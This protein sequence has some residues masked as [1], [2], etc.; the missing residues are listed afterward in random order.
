MTTEEIKEWLTTRAAEALQVEAHQVDTTLPLTSQGLDS[1]TLLDLT[2][3]L[4][5]WLG[6]DLSIPLLWQHPTIDALSLHLQEGEGDFSD[7]SSW[8]AP[9]DLPL[10]LSFAQERIWRIA[11]PRASA[12][13]NI[14]EKTFHLRGPVDVGL[15]D[16]SLQEVILRH[17][18]LRTTFDHEDGK[19]FQVV[20]PAPLETLQYSDV[21]SHPDADGEVVRRTRGPL[22]LTMDLAR[23]PLTRMVLVKIRENEYRL[24]LLFHHLLHDARSIEILG[25]E[26]SAIYIAF[27]K[28]LPSPLAPLP[29]Q[30]AD[31][32]A[33]QRHWLRKDGPEY[34]RQL[35]WWRTYWGPNVPRPARLPFQWGVPPD[36][37]QVSD[38]T[39]LQI[40]HPSLLTRLRGLCTH[41]GATL[42]M[43]LL[44][45]FEILL[46]HM[47][48]CDEQ[49][50]GTYVT[51]RRTISTDSL[52]GFFVNLVALRTDASQADTFSDT[53]SKVRTTLLQI[54]AHQDL[55][56]EHLCADF[57]AQGRSAPDV[58]ILFNHVKID[59]KLP[60]P[61]VEAIALDPAPISEMP[62][63]LTLHLYET[64]DVLAAY[65]TFDAAVYDPA[66]V[67]QFLQFYRH[68]LEIVISAPGQSN[69]D[70]LWQAEGYDP[71][72]LFS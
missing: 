40:F 10:E 18:I 14:V 45:A 41:E 65:V 55:P 56:F 30:V 29:L 52:I 35:S 17:E 33:W 47:T 12:D 32:S 2:G 50:F 36:S 57:E 39:Q 63:G 13:R 34:A 20:H 8:H 26:V 69:H 4:A 66:G 28:G 62:W 42:Y 7:P 68:L 46:T 23:G 49:V 19:P 67:S 37:V 21:S 43:V 9:R 5:Q 25:R 61:G 48:H 44:T 6:R 72:A 3:D 64:T 71:A 1:L 22:L 59:A 27:A 24:T 70:S 58:S 51:D 15:L 31:F 16:R 11:A 54:A 38:G 60:L 53:L